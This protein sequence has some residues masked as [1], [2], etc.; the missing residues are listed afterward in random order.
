MPNHCHNSLTIYN[1]I[2]QQIKQL[3]NI[4]DNG[5]LETLVPVPD[6][7]DRYDWCRTN[8]G[9]KLDLMDCDYSFAGTTASMSF[10]TAWSPPI[11]GFTK[12]SML[13][14]NAVFVSFYYECGADFVGKT[15]YKN[16]LI[17]DCDCLYSEV[18]VDWLKKKHPEFVEKHVDGDYNQDIEDEWCEVERDFL[19][20]HIDKLTH[21]K[22]EDLLK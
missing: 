14:P 3:K 7:V 18:Y 6:K 17:E 5:F 19:E 1:L 9:T 20:E 12:V 15:F 11:E 21:T 8:W 16:G 10:W 4:G 2:K 13:F 22:L